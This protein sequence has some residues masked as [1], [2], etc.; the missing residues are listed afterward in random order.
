[1]RGGP[2]SGFTN[3][4]IGIRE[5]PKLPDELHLSVERTSKQK[6]P[7]HTRRPFIGATTQPL[8]ASGGRV[9]NW[10]QPLVA[11]P[12]QQIEAKEIVRRTALAI[13]KYRFDLIV[14]VH[15]RQNVDDWECA[16]R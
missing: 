13:Q 5:G 12:K 8:Q 7:V 15:T 11:R 1:M 10:T 16:L 6:G 14:A 4:Q 9:R 3:N 2:G